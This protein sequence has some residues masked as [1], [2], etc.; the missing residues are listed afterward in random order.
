[1][2]PPGVIKQIIDVSLADHLDRVRYRVYSGLELISD[3]EFEAGLRRMEA[4]VAEEKQ[5]QPVAD[6]VGLL[7]FRK[8]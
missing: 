2:A 1:M 3:E 4:A 5:P 8:Q 6:Y 7:S